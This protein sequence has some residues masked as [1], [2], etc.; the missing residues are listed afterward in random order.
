MNLTITYRIVNEFDA[1]RNEG[2]VLV[3]R[4]VGGEDHQWDLMRPKYSRKSGFLNEEDAKSA[5][6][7]A[8]RADK[9]AATRL[10]ISLQTIFEKSP[11]GS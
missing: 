6:D 2:H 1:P 11:H 4:R 9:A 8:I 7:T 10:G 3:F 5:I